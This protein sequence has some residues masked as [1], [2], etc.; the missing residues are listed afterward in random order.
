[1]VLTTYFQSGDLIRIYSDN[2]EIM[3]DAKWPVPLVDVVEIEVVLES[4]LSAKDYN[5]GLSDY[6]FYYNEKGA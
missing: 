6:G 3:V 4:I 1:M 5:A 2:G